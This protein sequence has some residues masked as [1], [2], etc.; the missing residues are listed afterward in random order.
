MELA[1][2]EPR[3]AVG[4]SLGYA[5]VNRGGCELPEENETVCIG[6][7]APSCG[8]FLRGQGFAVCP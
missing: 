2:Y 8:G 5:V 6:S 1:A 3:R 7:H 4:Q